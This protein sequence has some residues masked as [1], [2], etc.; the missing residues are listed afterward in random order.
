L[1]NVS[2]LPSYPDYYSCPTTGVLT[3][4]LHGRNS[5]DIAA[6][7]GTPLL[8]SASGIVTISKSN[9]TWNGGYG[10][11]V[12]ISHDNGTQTLYAHMRNTV[13]APGEKVYQGTKIGYIGVS[14]MTTG[15]HVH[16]EVRG[17]KNPFAYIKCN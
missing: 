8:A 15:P 1:V 11:F 16:F 14:G 10:N 2:S 4:G 17:A 9:G 5:V 3:Q 7:V 12:V 6:P 13:V